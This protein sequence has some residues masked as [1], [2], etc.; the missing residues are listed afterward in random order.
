MTP[1][2]V[3]HLLCPNWNSPCLNPK[4]TTLQLDCVC[5]CVCV[6][7]ESI[8]SCSNCK[9]QQSYVPTTTANHKFIVL[10]CLPVCVCG[11]ATWRHDP[12]IS[13]SACW[14][15]GLGQLAL[16]WGPKGPPAD[17]GGGGAGPW[18][19]EPGFPG[20][21]CWYLNLC[22]SA[23]PCPRAPARPLYLPPPPCP[24]PP[25]DHGSPPPRG[26]PL[27]SDAPP[28]PPPRGDRHHRQRTNY[29]R[30]LHR[31]YD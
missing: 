14:G 13:G 7:R 21:G 19:A 18:L 6:P 22:L 31:I 11:R 30:I 16:S 20:F 10:P 12:A 2:S 23:T 3:P 5:V 8:Q 4:K 28:P 1:S 25:K 27:P 29:R 15:R 24:S 26:E 17:G 9:V